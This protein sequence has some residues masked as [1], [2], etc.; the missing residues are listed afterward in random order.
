MASFVPHE[1]T[2]VLAA[3]VADLEQQL[4]M[5]P[6]GVQL[7]AEEDPALTTR[8]E[9]RVVE[10]TGLLATHREILEKEAA[11]GPAS[12]LVKA[13]RRPKRR[14]NESLAKNVGVYDDPRDEDY[15]ANDADDIGV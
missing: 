5:S 8:L 2:R 9:A 11:A 7:P 14:I 4:G 1:P 10:L 3:R 12:Q 15:D 6:Q 13:V